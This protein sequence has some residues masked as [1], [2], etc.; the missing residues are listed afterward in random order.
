MTLTGNFQMKSQIVGPN[1]LENL[2][3]ISRPAGE[4][5]RGS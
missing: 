1:L 5:T 3:H 4:R 2:G